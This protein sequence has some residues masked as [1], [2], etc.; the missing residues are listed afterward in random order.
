MKSNRNIVATVYL[1][2]II[3]FCIDSSVS[4]SRHGFTRNSLSSKCATHCNDG[5]S[6]DL[7]ECAECEFTCGN[8]CIQN[9]SYR[10]ARSCNADT[11]KMARCKDCTFC[12]AFNGS[13]PI[14]TFVDVSRFKI[15]T[16]DSYWHIMISSGGGRGNDHDV[17]FMKSR[18]NFLLWGEEGFDKVTGEKTI[19]FRGGRDTARVAGIHMRNGRGRVNYILDVNG[20]GLLDI[21]CIH[22]RP[23]SNVIAP[24]V[25]LINQGNRTWIEDPNMSEYTR[26]MMV[27]D[28]D[29]DGYAQEIVLSRGFCFP[30]RDGPGS[31]PAND[32]GAF[33][34][35]ILHFCSSRPVGTTA[36]FKYNHSSQQMEEISKKYFN[37]SAANDKQPPCCPH[38]TWSGEGD[39]HIKSMASGDFDGD[40]LADHVMLYDRKMLFYFSSD[41]PVGTLPNESHYVGAEIPIPC[42]GESLRLIDL[43][44]DGTEEILILCRQAANFLVYTKGQTKNDWTL[45]NGCNSK[46][47]LGDI[48]NFSLA[49]FAE[50]DL[51][52]SCKMAEKSDWPHLTEACE[53]WRDRNK[54]PTVE[55]AGLSAVDLNNDGFIDAVVTYS[56]GYVRFF[57]NTPSSDSKANEFIIFRL[58]GGRGKS[59][60][61]GIGATA[62][63]YTRRGGFTLTQ[64]RE[65]ST[66]QHTTDKYGNKDDRI[67]FGLSQG[68]KTIKLVIRWP[69]G[70]EQIKWLGKWSFSGITEPIDIVEQGPSE[71]PSASRSK[72]PSTTP[73]SRPTF[74]PTNQP[75]ERPIEVL[76]M[77]PTAFPSL[78]PSPNPSNSPSISPSRKPSVP[79]SDV[80]SIFTTMTPSSPPSL[81]PTIFPSLNPSPNPS[82]SPSFTPSRKPSA[83]PSEVPSK[84]PSMTP[85]L[86]PSSGPTAFPSLN[87][88]ANPS[89]SP[90]LISKSCSTLFSHQ[91]VNVL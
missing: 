14:T 21:F 87:P 60:Q 3:H 47:S 74:L 75:S 55:T 40:L 5:K 35:D 24:G 46:G 27:T 33:S 65:V 63:L 38:G 37:I 30:Q 26:S 66:Y 58:I 80:P 67:F 8:K 85:S 9:S 18:D 78:N 62:I 90:M 7:F 10:C 52:D 6:C 82:S 4:T 20:D 56:M 29:G 25:L 13:C 64:F 28:A 23:V 61:Y 53:E 39:C 17:N 88:T 59:N 81:G 15:P 68:M 11:C 16:G 1:F 91:C 86:N 71:Y 22:D 32:L 50:N 48:V 12:D 45:D 89:N 31:D 79:P 34:D 77:I 2:A 57:H 72:I 19:I 49:G 54:N 84:F 73:S 70:N 69:T 36:V 44:N 51:I 83:T 76:S 43:D 42:K 41:R